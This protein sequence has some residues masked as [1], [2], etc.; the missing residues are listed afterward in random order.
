MALQLFKIASATVDSGGSTSFDF[1]SIPQGYTDLMIK[2]SVR[3]ATSGAND[4][5]MIRFN[6]DS[7]TTYSSRYLAADAVNAQTGSNAYSSTGYTYVTSITTGTYT[8]NSFSSVD[9]YI[10]NYTISNNK[11]FYAESAS[12]KNASDSWVSLVS[13]LYPITTAIS[14]ITLLTVSGSGYTQNSTAT[15]YGIL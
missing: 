11:N 9:I 6:N 12:E 10:P 1:T 2:V 3:G 14:R 13:G 7:S 5:F 4:G 15:L 8:A